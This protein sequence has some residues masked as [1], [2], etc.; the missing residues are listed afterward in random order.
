M[1]I[2]LSEKKQEEAQ[3]AKKKQAEEAQKQKQQEEAAPICQGVGMRFSDIAH[4]CAQNLLRR[5]S[6]TI[7]TVP[8]SCVINGPRR[9]ECDT[10]P[11]I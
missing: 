9:G 1:A 6:R 3:A 5:K 4:T 10:S 11:A 7:L 2:V 8:A